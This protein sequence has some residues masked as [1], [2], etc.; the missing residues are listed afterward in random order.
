MSLIFDSFKSR[1]DAE[2]FATHVTKTFK[3]ETVVY[4]SQEESQAITLRIR[5]T[6]QRAR[7]RFN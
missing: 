6:T 5:L 3:R 2:K 7:I 4:D 1:S